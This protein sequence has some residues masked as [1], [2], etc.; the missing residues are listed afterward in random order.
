MDVDGTG[1]EGVVDGGITDIFPPLYYYLLNVVYAL[2][3][4]YPGMGEGQ[5]C[6][7]PLYQG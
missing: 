7:D 3:I 5:G 4:P 1:K 6:V 2:N